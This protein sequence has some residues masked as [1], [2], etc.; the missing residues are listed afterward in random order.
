VVIAPA[1]TCR[2]C[3]RAGAFV[4]PPAGAAVCPLCGRGLDLTAGGPPAVAEVRPRAVR[5][6]CRHLLADTGGKMG[7]GS[8]GGGVSLKVYGCAKH[9]K[10]TLGRPADG[11]ACC[12]TCPDYQPAA[13]PA[14]RFAWAPVPPPA[15]ARTADRLVITVA[16]GSEGA[17]LH[18]ATGPSQRRYAARIGA[19]FVAITDRTQ[20]WPLMEKFRYRDWVKAYPGGTICIDADVFVTPAAPDLFALVPDH[21]VGVSVNAHFPTEP[22]RRAAFAT[23]LAAVCRSQGMSVPQGAEGTHWNSGLVVLRPAHADYWTP[24][25]RPLPG[26]WIDEELWSKVTTFARGWPVF[27]IPL[28]AHWQHWADRGATTAGPALGFVHPAGMGQTAGGKQDRLALLR[29]LQAAGGVA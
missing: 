2:V 19:D 16:T 22:K 18:A 11:L 21:S 29:L 8:C 14:S 9:G 28:A 17:E 20:A 4:P 15:I 25:A 24:P 12:G 1:T 27:D 26:Q 6:D 13:R 3:R 5:T 7:C 23:K 10:C